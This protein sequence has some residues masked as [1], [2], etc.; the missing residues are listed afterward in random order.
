MIFATTIPLNDEA[1]LH[2]LNVAIR[3]TTILLWGFRPAL[4]LPLPK[5]DFPKTS[6]GKIQR[7]TLRKRLENGEFSETIAYIEKMT[8]RQMG[9]YTPAAD[10][11]ESAIIDLY[12]D[13]FGIAGATIGATTSFS[14]LAER[15]WTSS[16]CSN[17]SIASLARRLA[18]RLQ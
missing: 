1:R 8:E 11:I 3:N 7:A 6:L 12:A 13:L 18:F 4:I 9:G 14:I 5:T 17:G 15:R 16:N 10:A 2:Q